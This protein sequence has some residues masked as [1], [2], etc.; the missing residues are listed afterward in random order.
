VTETLA[1]RMAAVNSVSLVNI[2]HQMNASPTQPTQPTQPTNYKTELM[3]ATNLTTELLFRQCTSE[4]IVRHMQQMLF[5]AMDDKNNKLL[6]YAPLQ[7][8]STKLQRDST[9]STLFPTKQQQNTVVE[10]HRPSF[11]AARA[12]LDV[13]GHR[14][15]PNYLQPSNDTA[16]DTTNNTTNNTANNTV[17]QWHKTYQRNRIDTATKYQYNWNVKTAKMNSMKNQITNATATVRAFSSSQSPNRDNNRGNSNN[18]L[19]SIPLATKIIGGMFFVGGAV[20]VVLVGGVFLGLGVLGVICAVAWRKLTG[21]P[22]GGGEHMY[23][24]VRNQQQNQH[25]QQNQRQGQPNRTM[26][27]DPTNDPLVR[28]LSKILNESPAMRTTFSGTQGVVVV[29]DRLAVLGKGSTKGVKRQSLTTEFELRQVKNG[30]VCGKVVASGAMKQQK[31]GRLS[32]LINPSM[33]TISSVHVETITK[34]RVD[35]SVPVHLRN[36]EEVE[37]EMKNS[38]QWDSF[39]G[40]FG[41]QSSKSGSNM[42]AE[43]GDAME[44][45]D[46]QE[47]KV[48]K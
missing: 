19:Q 17:A 25:N 10:V 31:Q 38:K 4:N 21:K 13:L 23:R 6:Q 26:E 11:V 30:T 46:V 15:V 9:Y 35:L 48:R 36:V 18:L 8:S 2:I 33:S 45:I 1:T 3:P 28:L 16:N 32:A 29:G 41:G 47:F 14:T 5:K 44:T 27:Y 43:R 7:M 39:K 12:I 34:R 24:F 20:T 42:A 40:M 37:R 22:M